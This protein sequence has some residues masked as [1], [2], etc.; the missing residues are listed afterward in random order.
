[1]VYQLEGGKG[2]TLSR[3]AGKCFLQKRKLFGGRYGISL[4]GRAD[5]VCRHASVYM[6]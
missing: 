1:M 2:S 6:M 5:Q 4:K 3:E